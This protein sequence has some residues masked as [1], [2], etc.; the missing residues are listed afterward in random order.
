MSFEAVSCVCEA[1]ASVVR[2]VPATRSTR[3][4]MHQ[5][6]VCLVWQRRFGGGK[7]TLHHISHQSCGPQRSMGLPNGKRNF[8]HM[9]HEA[10]ATSVDPLWSE[11]GG[12]ACGPLRSLREARQ[13]VDKVLYLQGFAFPR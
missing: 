6:R 9:I 8:S 7:I 13:Q 12:R 10:C 11:S 1:S 2:F 4:E 5:S 3:C